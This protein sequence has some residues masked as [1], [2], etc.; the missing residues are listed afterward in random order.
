MRGAAPFGAISH[1][2]NNLVP[3]GRP[4]EVDL[5]DLVRVSDVVPASV[6]FPAIGNHLNE[7]AAER[8]IRNVSDAIAIGFD[9]QFYFL[10]LSDGPLFDIFDVDAGIFDG[11]RFVASGHFNGQLGRHIG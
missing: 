4:F 11:N 5:D 10:I 7:G 1:Y 9:V 3:L 2:R 8:R 6:G